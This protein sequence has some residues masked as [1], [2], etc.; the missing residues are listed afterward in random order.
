[1][2]R[3]RF[4]RRKSSRGPELP[5]LWTLVKVQLQ[6][7][8]RKIKRFFDREVGLNPEDKASIGAFGESVAGRYL[9]SEGGFQIICRNWRHRQEE[10]DLV[11][12]DG[13]VLVF[14][15]VRTRRTDA[16]VSGFYSITRKKRNALQK[17]CKAYLR[18]LSLT[19]RHF[20]FDVVD[21]NYTNEAKYEV[22]HYENVPLFSKFYN[23]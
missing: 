16:L 18:R 5:D 11:A 14:V 19:P 9:E 6:E 23:P 12:W 10:V 3:D 21:V 20:R 17:V 13:E 8:G 7:I 2:N 22:Y 1:M 4:L 15:E